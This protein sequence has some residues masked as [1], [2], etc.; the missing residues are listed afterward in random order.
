MLLILLF[1]VF[2]SPLTVHLQP[3][4]IACCTGIA[5][6]RH[7]WTYQAMQERLLKLI[8]STFHSENR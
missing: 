3:H 1:S 5:S 6:E 7:I 8:Y 2:P 4:G